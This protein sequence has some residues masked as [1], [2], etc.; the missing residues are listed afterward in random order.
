MRTKV[1]AAMFLTA[2]LAADTA[3]AQQMFVFP[4]QGQTPQ[5]V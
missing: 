2:F 4:A 5:V 1:G 3:A